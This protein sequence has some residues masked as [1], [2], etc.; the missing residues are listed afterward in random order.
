M[1]S[2]PP[3]SRETFFRFL[4]ARFAIR[5]PVSMDPVKVMTGT[6]GFLTSGSPADLPY[7]VITFI[8]PGGRSE[9]HN[10]TQCKIDN[11]VISDGFITIVFPAA[12]AGDS[13]QPIS[14]KG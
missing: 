9:P 8:T 11:G 2:L 5:F 13:F 12:S 14:A 10:S 7:P 4:E 6:S 1:G 3:N